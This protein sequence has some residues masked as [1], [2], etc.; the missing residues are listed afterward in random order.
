MLT[1]QS[2]YLACRNCSL[3]KWCRGLCLWERKGRFPP[4]P[5]LPLEDAMV[6][7][8]RWLRDWEV[9]LLPSLSWGLGSVLAGT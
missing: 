3:L 7:L 8:R 2:T 4:H 1:T 5:R 9:F 6:K